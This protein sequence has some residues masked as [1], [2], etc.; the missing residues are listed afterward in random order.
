M[1]DV[2]MHT[3]LLVQSTSKPDSRTWSDYDTVEHC[4]EAISKIYEEVCV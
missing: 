4:M 3:I 1:A 2:G